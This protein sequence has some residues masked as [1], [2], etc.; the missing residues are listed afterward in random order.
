[1]EA[2]L[3]LACTAQR[4]TLSAKA[5]PRVERDMSVTLAPK[6]GLPMRVHD[7]RGPGANPTSPTVPPQAR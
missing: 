5:G 7:R 2:L 3:I 1:M 4:F 6:H